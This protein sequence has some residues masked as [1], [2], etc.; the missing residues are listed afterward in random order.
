VERVARAAGQLSSRPLARFLY[1][2][3]NFPPIIEKIQIIGDR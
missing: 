3:A 2:R 1:A